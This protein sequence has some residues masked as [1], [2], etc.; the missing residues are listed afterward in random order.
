[1]YAAEDVCH[2]YVY[3]RKDEKPVRGQVNPNLHQAAYKIMLWNIH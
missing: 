2:C 3:N 1:M